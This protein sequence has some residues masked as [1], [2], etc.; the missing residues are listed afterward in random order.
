MR[1]RITRAIFYQVESGPSRVHLGAKIA[2]VFNADSRANA[3]NAS[4]RNSLA[5]LYLKDF[6]YLLLVRLYLL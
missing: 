6:I 1:L 3:F 2:P 4:F 5:V